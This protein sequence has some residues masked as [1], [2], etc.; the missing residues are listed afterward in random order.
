MPVGA[1]PEA[2]GA[3]GA[4]T[5]P[6]TGLQWMDQRRGSLPIGSLHPR[7]ST[8]PK[9]AL[10]ALVSLDPRNRDGLMHAYERSQA[11]RTSHGWHFQRLE[12]VDRC[13]NAWPQRPK[14]DGCWQDLLRALGLMS[15]GPNLANLATLSLQR[16][17]SGG[18]A[19]R[20]W[21]REAG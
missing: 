13:D 9:T 21:M 20:T 12:S 5:M 16:A 8:F 18:A 15:R 4:E 17:S 11:S 10:D 2:N 19:S 14:G 6:Q 1:I 3:R 7:S